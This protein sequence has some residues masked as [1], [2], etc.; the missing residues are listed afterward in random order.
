M[1][2]MQFKRC[3]KC[4]V[5]G[6]YDRDEVV[7]QDCETPLIHLA[8]IPFT[9]LERLQSI[10]EA[11]WKIAEHPDSKAKLRDLLK[12]IDVDLEV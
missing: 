12:I 8:L 7:C 1:N 3:P 2:E 5:E 9:E 10:E 6:M 4:C 11:V